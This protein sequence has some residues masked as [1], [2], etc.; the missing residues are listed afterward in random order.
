MCIQDG[1]RIG[2]PRTWRSHV[3][4]AIFPHVTFH[5]DCWRKLFFSI[6][7][8]SDCEIHARVKIAPHASRLL[9]MSRARVVFIRDYSQPV[10]KKGLT[11]HFNASAASLT[12]FVSLKM[13]LNEKLCYH[14]P[15]SYW[16]GKP[17]LVRKFVSRQ[18][19]HLI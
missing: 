10:R 14:L 17:D 5:W 6:F 12:L 16:R 11:S 2:E 3:I 7:C 1:G 15:N 4:H 19:T 9:E 18:K 13:T 8:T